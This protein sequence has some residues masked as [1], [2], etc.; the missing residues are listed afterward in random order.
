MSSTPDPK[1]DQINDLKNRANEILPNV[2]SNAKEGVQPSFG[3]LITVLRAGL[4]DQDI[5]RK[6]DELHD[7]LNKDET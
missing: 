4:F 6:G 2:I 5:A 3:D 7:A 1:K